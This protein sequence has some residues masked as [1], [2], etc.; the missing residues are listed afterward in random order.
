MGR[1]NPKHQG[2][3][4]LFFLCQGWVNK[5]LT[6][7]TNIKSLRVGGPCATRTPRLDGVLSV[8]RWAEQDGD[9]ALWAENWRLPLL[10]HLSPPSIEAQPACRTEWVIKLCSLLIHDPLIA[11]WLPMS[12][13]WRQGL[14]R[15]WGGG[16]QD[17]N[18][19]GQMNMSSLW[20]G[21]TGN[22]RHNGVYV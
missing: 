2:V 7:R 11:L 8:I 9:L 1:I 16:G 3:F 6:L 13:W 4:L 18:H 5:S 19:L 14:W 22:Q 21:P 15:R 12:C 17:I 20:M 10:F